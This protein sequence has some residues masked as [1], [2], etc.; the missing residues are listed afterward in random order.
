MADT[1]L[2]G[3]MVVHQAFLPKGYLGALED[4]PYSW[5]SKRPR[6][7]WPNRGVTDPKITLDVR[8][9]TDRMEMAQSIQNTFGQV[10]I[11]VE[12]NIGDGKPNS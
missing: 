1:F 9:A 11:T 7:C 8:N 12:L 4:T 10:G 2:K 3:S 5:T 6:R